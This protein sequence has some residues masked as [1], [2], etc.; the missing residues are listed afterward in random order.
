MSNQLTRQIM[1]G[2]RDGNRGSAAGVNTDFQSDAHPK[3]AYFL[4]LNSQGG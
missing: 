2:G 4:F 3:K 1:K